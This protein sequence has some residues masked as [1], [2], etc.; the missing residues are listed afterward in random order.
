MRDPSR[1][2][3]ERGVYTGIRF[4]KDN[5]SI[6]KKVKVY[7]EIKNANLL[8]LEGRKAYYVKTIE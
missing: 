2:K 7:A 8:I 6:G 5:N 4:T 3:K 1:P